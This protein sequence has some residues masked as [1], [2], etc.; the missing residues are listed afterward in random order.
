MAAPQVTP[1]TE[2]R[3][4]WGFMVWEPEDGM[5]TR[6]QITLLT[7]NGVQTA[8]LVLGKVAVGAA[9]FAALGTNTG[10]PTCGAITVAAPAVAG[11]YDVIMED[12]THFIVLQTPAGG[13]G[14]GEEIGHGVFGAAFNAG[15]LGFT[16]TAGGTPCIDTDSFKITVA[17]GSGKYV[18]FDPT[19][20]DGREVVAG[21]L[22]SYRKDTTSAD[23]QAGALVRGPARLNASELL[24]SAGVTT[25]PQV[26]AAL[27][28]LSALGIQSSLGTVALS[29]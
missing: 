13:G 25:H 22:G 20:N 9:A 4:A 29:P 14:A 5:V 7:G 16:I 6:Q 3:H 28:A 8:G 1:I 2:T 18:P 12:A 11:E 17:A 19:G 27:A 15:G 10:N 21:I 24:W 23:Q 26:V